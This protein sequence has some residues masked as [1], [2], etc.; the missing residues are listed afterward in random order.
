MPA[1][2]QLDPR[3]AQHFRRAVDADRL[4]RARA[5]QF[6]HPPGAG[7]D[8][9]QPAER[10]LAKRAVDRALDLALG[11]VERADRVPHLGVGGEIARRRPRRGRRGPR[12]AGR[13]R[14]RTGRASSGSAQRRCSA[15]SGS[16]RVRVGQLRNTQLPSLRRS[17]EA[18]VDQDLDVARDPRLA[19]PEHLRELADRQLHRPEQRE[20]AQPRRVGEGLKKVGEREVPKP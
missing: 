20:D 9:D 14:R 17:S 19:L 16:V 1:A 8:I 2:S 12:R 11:D 6:D 4:R 18:G 3:E 13:R 15:N 5:E 7:A 10:P